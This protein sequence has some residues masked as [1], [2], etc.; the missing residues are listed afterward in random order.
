MWG[1]KGGSQAVL[2]RGARWGRPLLLL[3]EDQGW[4][5]QL[6]PQ[7]GDPGTFYVRWYML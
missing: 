1:L 2:N 6:A 4:R 5:N 7:V 3:A